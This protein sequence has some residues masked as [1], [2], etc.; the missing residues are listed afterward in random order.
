MQQKQ[1]LGLQTKLKVNEPGDIYEREAD[2]VAD[3]VMAAPTH[4]TISEAPPRIQRFSGQSQGQVDAVPASVGQALASLGRPLE[5][6]LRQDMEQRFGHDLS[7][8][9]VHTDPRAVESARAVS[10][11]AYT[12]GRDIIF[13]D[14]QYAP[15]SKPGRKLLAHELTHTIQQ[16][17]VASGAI[18]PHDPITIEPLGIAFERAGEESASRLTTNSGALT[19]TPRIALQRAPA[20]PDEIEFPAEYAFALDER[21]RTWRRYARSEGQ[22]DAARIRRSGKLSSEDRQEVNAKL[23]FFEGEA[24]EVYIREI[25]PTLSQV[26]PPD[27]I[28]M[29]ETYESYI[30]KLPVAE[31]EK[32]IRRRRHTIQFFSK[33]KDY[34]LE[35]AYISRLQ[36]YLDEGLEENKYWDLEAIEQIVQERA[37]N[38][39]WREKARQ[40]FLAQLQVKLADPGKAK[41]SPK[42]ARLLAEPDGGAFR[43]DT[44]MA[45]RG[46]ISGAGPAVEVV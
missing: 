5:P 6:A 37:P 35:R 2:R 3:Q 13:A 41:A 4:S 34:Q 9:R 28:D 31:G 7:N 11:R 30:G 8:V 17:A 20:P 36:R 10:A 39:P 19:E 25:R 26:T 21:R 16:S 27:R 38:A 40:E 24:R 12:V 32:V 18:S 1:R 15:D 45:E 23:D 42:V 43:T 33:I 44:G 14:G 46:T 22:K 29:P